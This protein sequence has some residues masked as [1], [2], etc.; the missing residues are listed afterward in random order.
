MSL[1]SSPPA[2]P[3]PPDR[4]VP[5]PAGQA[6]P[7]PN[8]GDPNSP[9]ELPEPSEPRERWL[10]LLSGGL[11]LLALLVGIGRDRR[12]GESQFQVD[13]VAPRAD[14]LQEGME[15]RLS[16]LP[17]GRVE[18]VELQRD[19]R[20]AVKL[21]INDRH[22]NLLGPRSRAQSGQ[23]GLV[24]PTFLSLTPDPQPE[25]QASSRPLPPLA[26]DPPPDLNQL[27]AQLAQ[28]RTRLDQTLAQASTLLNRQVPSSLGSLERSTTRLS[29]SMGDLSAMAKTLSSETKRT[30]PSVRTLTG[31]LQR[32]VVQVA[33]AVR[34]T[35]GR[36][37]QTLVRADQTADSAVTVSREA[38]ELL[39]QARPV[40]I[41]TL[42][43]VREITGA[44]DRL[45]RFLSGLGLAEPSHDRPRSS[46]PTP[47]PSPS[48]RMDPYKP[49]PTGPGPSPYAP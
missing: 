48:E 35:L 7:P 3:P 21:R 16:G 23:V 25:G 43:N 33:P 31:T 24:G 18:S 37:D 9:R 45:V 22:R 1:P 14:G 49:H 13:V 44:A 17:I 20:V 19:A 26:Y 8:P 29:G 39:R 5:D 32:E 36:A 12:W 27:I 42:E 34:R 40:L 6:G 28:S 41:P 38:T 15:V 10:F 30:V 2:S 4:P 11:L 47:P 46:R